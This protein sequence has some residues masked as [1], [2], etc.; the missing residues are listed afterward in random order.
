MLNA[1]QVPTLVAGTGRSATKMSVNQLPRWPR[2]KLSR[3]SRAR[4]PPLP[5]ISPVRAISGHNAL[6]FTMRPGPGPPVG[7][8]DRT[9]QKNTTRLP[10]RLSGRTVGHAAQSPSL[11][12]LRSG[13]QFAPRLDVKCAP[14]RIGSGQHTRLKDAERCGCRMIG[15]DGESKPADD[16]ANR[17]FRGR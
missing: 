16:V 6:Q 11:P 9:K 14:S 4:P 13:R 8:S 1:P 5:N 10:R 15:P 2:L 3:R 12:S 17:K 7:L